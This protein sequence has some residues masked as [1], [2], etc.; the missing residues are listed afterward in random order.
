MIFAGGLSAA[1]VSTDTLFAL[2]RSG[3]VTTLAPL[4]SAIH[5]AAAAPV[6]ARLL[7][8]GGGVSEG[9]DHILQIEPGPP[10]QVGTL[11]RALSDLVAAPIGGVAYVTGGWDGTAT[12]RSIYAV[13]GAAHVRTV[14]ALPLGVRYPAAGALGGRLIIAGGEMTSG[15]PTDRVWSFD[16]R[17]GRVS[18]LPRLPTPTDHAAGVVLAGRFYVVGGLRRGALTRSIVS[19]APG[20]T[21]WRGS[22]ALPVAISDA[23]AIP[24]G[25]GIAVAGGRA[26]TGRV[27]TITVLEPRS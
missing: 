17:S 21:H 16:P 14:G 10:R 3:A 7:V 18:Q 8:F 20:E 5:D 12:N 11:P 4:P 22:G 25:G 23:S 15:S 2:S 19:W 26:A 27:A 13:T 6:G 9:S 1:D 24:F